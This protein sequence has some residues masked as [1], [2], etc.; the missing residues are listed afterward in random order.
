MPDFAEDSARNFTL[1]LMVF[2]QNVHAFN[3]R[4]EVTSAFNVPL[5][6]N[7]IL[8]GGVI[9]AQLIHVLS[10][11]I[12]FMQNILR[13]EPVPLSQWGLTLLLAVPI[14]LSME[15]FKYLMR[16]KP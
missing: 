1:L 7:L 9:C 5:K 16:H 10:M 15:V 12:G 13:V 14:L 2:L 11:Q 4:S 8:V 3:C 6:R